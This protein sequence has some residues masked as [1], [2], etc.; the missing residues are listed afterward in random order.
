MIDVRN[1]IP[2]EGK[3][4]AVKLTQPD[5]GV[6]EG[7]LEM[8]DEPRE[9]GTPWNGKTGQ[10]LQ[11]DI[12]QCSLASG[13]TI[14]AGDLVAVTKDGSGFRATVDITFSKDYSYPLRPWISI[15]SGD[16]YTRRALNGGIL[17]NSQD[18]V[19]WYERL[20]SSGVLS[21]K[22]IYS[23]FAGDED[24]YGI[25]DLGNVNYTSIQ[26]GI[27]RLTNDKM[28]VQE[29]SSVG[30]Y[31]LDDDD[32]S[33][34]KLYTLPS[35]TVCY[36]VC[37]LG[38]D[39]YAL[40][41]N[42][43]IYFFR[44]VDGFFELLGQVT[45][46]LTSSYYASHYLFC[47]GNILVALSGGCS[48]LYS[49]ACKYAFVTFDSTGAPVGNASNGTLFNGVNVDRF[50]CSYRN[51]ELICACRYTSDSKLYGCAVFL[52]SKSA[53]SPVQIR[54]MTSLRSGQ[55]NLPSNYF[56]V[57]ADNKMYL[58][59]RYASYIS[60]INPLQLPGTI[61]SWVQK[62][63][64]GGFA[65]I[66]TGIYPIVWEGTNFGF[67][68]T[69]SGMDG[70]ALGSGS[71]PGTVDVLLDGIAFTDVLKSS[72]IATNGIVVKKIMDGAV[73]AFRR[74][75]A[76]Q[77]VTGSYTG[78]GSYGECN[79]SSIYFNSPIAGTTIANRPMFI[80][81]ISEDLNTFIGPAIWFYGSSVLRTG[82]VG[83]TA[84][85]DSGKGGCLA[86]LLS[87]SFIWYNKHGAQY[88]LN[89]AGVKYRYFAILA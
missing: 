60:A 87:G 37:S 26:Q 83:S 65:F 69:Q 7:I 88:Q 68:K 17:L 49:S 30:V 6:V 12:R 11:A 53:S 10:L 19:L 54:T 44:M 25:S 33:M 9:A 46:Q 64:T 84:S 80:A 15:P 58:L 82:Y 62:D 81:I 34:S 70:I 5:G 89:A 56:A 38:G 76:G 77:I 52:N 59:I 13:K 18:V 16:G 41:G 20:N 35:I 51:G 8:A 23:T 42:G 45:V 40:L 29:V 43:V 28:V 3:E 22:G 21:G 75:R 74:N 66:D 27:F 24:Y 31:K 39:N 4:G 14:Q 50:Q 73:Q 85:S 48:D 79:Y 32:Y 1:R 47:D 86:N 61:F 57:D 36:A 55:V 71:Y 78:T 72:I 67:E 63:D 2:E